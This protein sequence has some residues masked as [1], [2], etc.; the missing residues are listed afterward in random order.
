M[1][2]S[3]LA[4]DLSENGMYRVYTLAKVLQRR[5]KVEII[6]SIFGKG[7]YEPCNT[8]EFKFKNA[9]GCPFPLFI[10]SIK[11]IL[12]YITGD[13]IYA[14]KPLFTSYGIALLKKLSSK[15]P[16]V[17]DIDD[18]PVGHWLKEWGFSLRKVLSRSKNLL[19]FWIPNGPLYSIIISKYFTHIADNITV[20]SSFLQKKFGGV[21]IPHAQD[22]VLFD[23]RRFK[24]N[25][26]RQ[27]WNLNN[28]KIIMFFGTPIPHKGIEDI[29]Q[30]LNRL[31]TNKEIKLMVVGAK[32]ST[33]YI[34]QLINTGK[35]KIIVVEG[36]QPIQKIPE[37]LSMADLVVL[38]QRDTPIT[39]AQVP[40]KLIDAMAM[41]KPII[42]T[43]VSDMPQILEG[44]GL[45]V[46]P[47]DIDDLADKISF[48]VENEKAAEKLGEKAREKCKQEF[49]FDVIEKKLAEVFDKFDKF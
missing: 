35:E 2:I 3:I 14:Y 29:L 28:K 25:E 4:H 24:R 5:Y 44:C 18:W 20:T 39:A 13:V 34:Q 17:I 11:K 19:K 45:I 47:N 10:Y 22:I 26:L 42:S 37:F 49:S 1:K 9:K 31:R 48:L 8:G 27:R 46:K 23:P 6:G 33:H 16:V 12:R 40:A 32:K 36:F 41:A 43:N 7:I 38:P 15:Y 30:A 21:K